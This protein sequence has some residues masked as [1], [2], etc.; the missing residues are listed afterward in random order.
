VPFCF[1]LVWF[2]LVWFGL[3]WFGLVWFGLVWFGLV[4]FGLVVYLFVCL[5]VCLFINLI[6]VLH[7]RDVK[8]KYIT[9]V[10]V[11]MYPHL[12]S[13][14][15]SPHVTK[16]FFLWPYIDLVFGATFVL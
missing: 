3:V 2:G 12:T 9:I 11:K 16:F 7:V 1:C 13:T 15:F 4:W 10:T 8:S 6:N 5:S 14:F